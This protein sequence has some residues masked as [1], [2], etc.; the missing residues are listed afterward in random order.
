MSRPRAPH[1]FECVFPLVRVAVQPRLHPLCTRTKIS[2][3]THTLYGHVGDWLPGRLYIVDCF[4]SHVI[5]PAFAGIA[6]SLSSISTVFL[7]LS[8]EYIWK[9]PHDGATLFVETVTTFIGTTRHQRH[10]PPSPEP[11]VMWCAEQLSM[12]CMCEPFPDYGIRAKPLR[13]VCAVV[14]HLAAQQRDRQIE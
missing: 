3:R 10:K 14:H 13:D 11:Q 9:S 8:H 4:R 12:V 2:S 5:V 7:N 6:F 1:A